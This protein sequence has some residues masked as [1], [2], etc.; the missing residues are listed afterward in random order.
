MTPDLHGFTLISNTKIYF[1]CSLEYWLGA[2]DEEQ[3]QHQA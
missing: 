3:P 1:K 2:N